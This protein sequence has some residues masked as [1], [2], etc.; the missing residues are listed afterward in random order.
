MILTVTLNAALDDTYEVPDVRFGEVNR[1]AA[2]HRRP[3]GKG[4]NVARV[5]HGLGHEVTAAGLVGGVT[6][7]QIEEGL[8]SLGVPASFT[9]ASGESRRTVTVVGDEVTVFNEPG[10][11]VTGDEWAAFLSDYERLASDAAVAVLSGSLPP[12]V[13]PDAYAELA[14]RAPGPVILDADGEPLRLGLAGRPAVVK[15]NAGELARATG[16]GDPAAG[17]RTLRDAGAT[18]VVV[19]LGADGVL[20]GTPDGVLRAALDR[21]EPGNPTGAGDALAAGLAAGL[22]EGLPWPERL[23]NAVAL[24]ACA[25]RSPV[26]GE[27][28]VGELPALLSRVAVRTGEGHAA[29]GHE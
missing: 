11:A 8:A 23:R 7:L 2:V 20:A 4:V 17:I 16:T 9:R 6:G 15:P 29:R 5:L 25:V 18:A 19:S 13:P 27:V 21:P 14:R 22:A 10:P 12:G 1:V 26:A 28:D 24:A 3:G